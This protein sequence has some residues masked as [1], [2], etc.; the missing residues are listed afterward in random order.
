MEKNAWFVAENITR[1]IDDTPV[2]S[3]YIRVFTS[4]RPEDAFFVFEDVIKKFQKSTSAAAKEAVPGSAYIQNILSF[5]ENHYI[6]GELFMEFI[7]DGFMD[8]TGEL[9]KYCQVNGWIGENMPRV[10][11][12]VP[13]LQRPH[14]Y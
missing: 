12:P 4:E 14:H 11:Q 13:N 3:N 8:A 5:Y 7:K 1:R 9:C 2:L 10:P 6:H